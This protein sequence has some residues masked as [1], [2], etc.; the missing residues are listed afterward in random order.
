MPQ[1]ANIANELRKKSHNTFHAAVRL[2]ADEDSLQMVRMLCHYARPEYTDFT[3]MTKNQ[4]I[5]ENAT[6]KCY[7]DWANWTWLRPLKDIGF[8]FTCGRRGRSS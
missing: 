7:A 3:D 1:T 4:L 2:M 5:G 6:R 8:L